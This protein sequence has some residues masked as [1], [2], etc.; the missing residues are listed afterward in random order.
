MATGG[1]DM[2]VV[3]SVLN[4]YSGWALYARGFMLNNNVKLQINQVS[5]KKISTKN[6]KSYD[7]KRPI[8][9]IVEFYLLKIPY[10]AKIYRDNSFF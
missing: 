2:P 7:N 6:Q 3:I 1:A 8:L 5:L 9:S 10:N 4:S